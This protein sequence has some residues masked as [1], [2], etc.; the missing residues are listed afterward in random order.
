[1]WQTRKGCKME[2]KEEDVKIEKINI[3]DIEKEKEDELVDR[4]M[5]QILKI[6]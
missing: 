5:Q 3:K 2:E 6:K 1:M 4:V